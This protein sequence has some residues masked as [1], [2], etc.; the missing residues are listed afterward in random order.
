MHNIDVRLQ[1]Q[2]LQYKY[3]YPLSELNPDNADT[4]QPNS[5]FMWISPV[6]DI[7]VTYQWPLSPRW[8]IRLL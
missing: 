5:I 6:D 1:Y 8:R 7:K 4:F 3:K 2:N